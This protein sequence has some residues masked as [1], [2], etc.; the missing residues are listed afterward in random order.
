[1]NT[2][3]KVAGAIAAL[4]IIGAALVATPA[5]ASTVHIDDGW[6]VAAPH[7]GAKGAIFGGW[8]ECAGAQ[9]PTSIRE[10]IFRIPP[11]KNQNYINTPGIKIWTYHNDDVWNWHTFSP[12]RYG[13]NTT[14][15]CPD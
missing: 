3:S 8:G 12:G 15:H 11:G 4:A 7:K 10:D 6:A 14:V 2:K 9:E 1:M 13:V 5:Q